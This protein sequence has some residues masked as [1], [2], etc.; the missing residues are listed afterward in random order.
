[1]FSS[2]F[3]KWFPH[4]SRQSRAKQGPLPRPRGKRVRRPL[5]LEL[6]EDRVVPATFT[7]FPNAD[8]NFN[9]AANW[10]NQGGNPGVPGPTDDANINFSGITVTL[11]ESHTV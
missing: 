10:R 5:Q 6:L 7:W 1:M 8:G 2:W 3:R 4:L 11:S 9:V